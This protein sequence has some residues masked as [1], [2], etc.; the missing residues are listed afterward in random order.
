MWLVRLLT[1]LGFSFQMANMTYLGR[2]SKVRFIR[3]RKWDLVRKG[4]VTVSDALSLKCGYRLDEHKGW[5]FDTV[6]GTHGCVFIKDGVVKIGKPA[7]D[8]KGKVKSELYLWFLELKKFIMSDRY[9]FGVQLSIQRTGDGNCSF[10]VRGVD[11]TLNKA[12][13]ITTHVAP[14]KVDA[15]LAFID[16]IT[17]AKLALIDVGGTGEDFLT[18]PDAFQEITIS[19]TPGTIF[20][21]LND[22]SQTGYRAFCAHCVTT[23]KWEGIL[24]RHISD[25]L[26]V[27][28]VCDAANLQLD[29]VT[30]IDVLHVT[31]NE[32]IP[33]MLS[34]KNGST[35]LNVKLNNG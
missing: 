31:D 33:Y 17:T 1:W 25:K 23:N 19:Y 11:H 10:N 15:D 18:I 16:V 26:D 27:V 6:A 4:T 5:Y 24:K 30:G 9:A 14:I 29:E 3:F 7:S 32:N 28:K 13:D 21:T 2:V 12:G 8:I 34:H 35:L 20:I 22:Q